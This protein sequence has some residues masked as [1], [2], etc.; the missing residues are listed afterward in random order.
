MK[1]KNKAFQLVEKGLSQKTVANLTETQIDILH[2]KM[3]G[4]QIRELPMTKKY[5]IGPTGGSLPPNPKGYEVGVDPVTKKTVAM[6]KE[7]EVKEDETDDV[8]SQNALGK[9]AMQNYTGEE[10]PHD[11]NDMGDDGMDDDSG[12]D[13]KMMGM[14]E[15]KKKESNPWAICTSQL[16][17][18]FGT[19][20]RHLWS[21]KEKN[22]YERCVKD[23]KKSLKEGKN[24]VSLFLE[25]EIYRIV[26]KHLPPRIT[27]GELMKHLSENSPS[28]APTKPK[29]TTKPGKPDVKPR[30]MRPGQNP[31]PGE[32]EAPRAKGP[33]M[34]AEEAKNKVIKSIKDILLHGKKN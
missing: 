5:E 6:A 19:R 33:K 13:R 16:G 7:A 25:N 30:P 2:K 8:T 21:S 17:K 26:E 20:E 11:A 10:E 34:S 32:K 29:P 15:A 3:I 9:D 24:P 28:T 14:A 31:H 27:K 12:D 4:E 23:V 18:E 22:K 1:N